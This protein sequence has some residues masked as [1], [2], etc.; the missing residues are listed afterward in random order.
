MLRHAVCR[1]ITYNL[2]YRGYDL[3]VSRESAGW[4]VGVY[5]RSADL[6]I[7]RR[8]EVLAPEQDAAVVAA[9]S[10]IDRVLKL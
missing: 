8:S 5:P 6:P 10:N 2:L 1:E 9:K 4:K 3:E 7:L